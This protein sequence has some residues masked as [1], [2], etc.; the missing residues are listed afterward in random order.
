MYNL[1][2]RNLCII[3]SAFARFPILAPLVC[4]CMKKSLPEACAALPDDIAAV[5]KNVPLVERAV[6]QVM[7]PMPSDAPVPP[8][9][10][11]DIDAESIWAQAQ[12][13]GCTQLQE[14][15]G[16]DSAKA[17]A[18]MQR[19]GDGE[20]AMFWAVEHMDNMDGALQELFGS[21][22]QDTPSFDAALPPAPAIVKE[23]GHAEAVRPLQEPKAVEMYF[24]VHDTPDVV[25]KPGWAGVIE[26]EISLMYHGWAEREAISAAEPPGGPHG[27]SILHHDLYTGVFQPSDGVVAAKQEVN[28]VAHRGVA[29]GA[30]SPREI[31]VHGP[32]LCF[33]P[34][35]NMLVVDTT[36]DVA[37]FF[38]VARLGA[39]AVV[40]FHVVLHWRESAE[41]Q[42][43][44]ALF[45][46]IDDEVALEAALA[47]HDSLAGAQAAWQ[48]IRGA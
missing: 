38:S 33:S 20:A 1:L 26:G 24:L 6:E 45:N 48:R 42:R 39:R 13:E 27:F 21:D 35:N 12:S 29:F 34:D 14:A 5:L 10:S 22:G 31:H 7:V 15:L 43:L 40:C 28:S 3:L 11:A 36:E 30:L 25:T 47:H 46:R 18:L 23:V 2:L 32:G 19:F 4:V 37:T 17:L 9:A 16:L 8:C 41:R 44:R